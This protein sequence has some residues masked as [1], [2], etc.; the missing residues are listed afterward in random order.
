M[1]TAKGIL[2]LPDFNVANIDLE[3]WTDEGGGV[4]SII[5]NTSEFATLSLQAVGDENVDAQVSVS[6]EGSNDG[7]N[8]GE[9]TDIDDVALSVSITANNFDFLE[10]PTILYR[11][12]IKVKVNIGSATVGIVKFYSK[13]K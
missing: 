13:L 4:Y 9:L 2:D 3:K 11:R 10:S 8:F 1:C 6:L 7:S 5:D 12:Y